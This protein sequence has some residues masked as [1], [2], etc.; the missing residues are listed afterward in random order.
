MQY[1]IKMVPTGNTTVNSQ[2]I[3]ATKQVESLPKLALA[4]AFPA[5]SPG[6]AVDSGPVENYCSFAAAAGLGALTNVWDGEDS[7]SMPQG[8]DWGQN[9]V[10]LRDDVAQGAHAVAECPLAGRAHQICLISIAD[11]LEGACQIA[12]QAAGP[13]AEPGSRP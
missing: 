4:S 9:D 3:P 5:Y 6:P 12:M 2:I 10:G 11:Q 13:D 1:Y 8:P 7:P